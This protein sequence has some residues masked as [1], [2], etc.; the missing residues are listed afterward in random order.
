M[1]R[2]KKI[3]QSNKPKNRSENTVI[4][5]TNS[6]KYQP[7]QPT[8]IVEHFIPNENTNDNS[9]DDDHSVNTIHTI[10]TLGTHQTATEFLAPATSFSMPTRAFRGP[11]FI[12]T[13]HLNPSQYSRDILEEKKIQAM[14]YHYSTRRTRNAMQSHAF[15]SQLETR[16]EIDVDEIR[17][18]PNKTLS[19]DSRSKAKNN[20][21]ENITKNARKKPAKSIIRVVHNKEATSEYKGNQDTVY[22]ELKPPKGTDQFDDIQSNSN[23]GGE[24]KEHSKDIWALDVLEHGC[25]AISLGICGGL[26]D[27]SY[28]DNSLT[29]AVPKRNQHRPHQMR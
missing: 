4:D 5:A 15:W 18:S 26:D 25:D 14:R 16:Y 6:Y 23:R 19:K 20:S 8:I 7:H 12:A 1:F 29:E 17:P 9:S 21:T 10:D 2:L 22:S 13:K 27:D 11:S 24:K 3:K 28:S